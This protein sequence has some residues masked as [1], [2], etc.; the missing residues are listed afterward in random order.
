MDSLD[1]LQSLAGL[2]AASESVPVLRTGVIDSSYVSS[3]YPGTLPKITFDGESTLS[4]KR[5]PVVGPYW[6]TASD[7]VLLA[8]IGNTYGIIGALDTDA[9]LRSG[10]ALRVVGATSLLSTLNVTGATSLGSTLG[11][12]GAA[13]LSSTLGVSGT[14][15]M[16]GAATVGTTITRA[17]ESW[18]TLSLASSW[19]GTFRVRRQATGSVQWEARLTSSGNRSDGTTIFTLGASYRPANDL[20]L[21]L[22][23]NAMAG[24]TTESPHFGITA[25]DGTVRCYGCGSAGIIGNSG[26]YALD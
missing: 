14:V 26:T 2:A 20:S 25:S 15:T 7:R 18:Q 21:V 6:P 17:S 23:V 9:A 19:S 24:G 3:T 4:G 5:Y 10:G 11:V 22:A 8:A 16:S 12:T 13:T 1:I